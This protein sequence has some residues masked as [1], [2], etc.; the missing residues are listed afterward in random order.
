MRVL[1][2]TS[3][4]GSLL[5]FVAAFIFFPELI[6]RKYGILVFLSMVVLIVWMAIDTVCA[7]KK[8]TGRGP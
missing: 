3:I 1:I 7:A 4:K 5:A 6:P 2:K 8:F